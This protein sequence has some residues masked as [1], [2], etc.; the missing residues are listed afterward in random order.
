[1]KHRGILTVP[2]LH[3]DKPIG[4]DIRTFR[5]IQIEVSDERAGGYASIE[6]KAA[7]FG[8]AADWRIVL[9]RVRPFPG[10]YLPVACCYGAEHVLP[11]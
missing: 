10:N 6:V 9:D 4:H 2:D 5:V 3:I 7:Y 1:M 8:G 11:N